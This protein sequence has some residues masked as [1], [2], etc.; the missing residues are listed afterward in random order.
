MSNIILIGVGALGIRLLSRITYKLISRCVN[1]CLNNAQP[2]AK[3]T[4][5]TAYHS[6]ASLSKRSSIPAKTVLHSTTFYHQS[7]FPRNFSSPNYAFVANQLTETYP[8]LLNPTSDG[9]CGIW[10]LLAILKLS[11]QEND[12]TRQNISRII[13]AQCQLL[14][15]DRSFNLPN[16]ANTA[17]SDRNR[18]AQGLLHLETFF[19]NRSPTS[20]SDFKNQLNQDEHLS[21]TTALA[22]RFLSFQLHEASNIS[23]PFINDLIES[24]QNGK[25][26][27]WLNHYTMMS[28]LQL[29][30]I[31]NVPLYAMTIDP[32]GHADKSGNAPHAIW[33]E[34]HLQSHQNS[35]FCIILNNNHYQVLLKHNSDYRQETHEERRSKLTKSFDSMKTTADNKNQALRELYDMYCNS[36]TPLEVKKR[37]AMTVGTHKKNG[38][39]KIASSNDLF[40]L[41][42]VMQ[43][44]VFA[45]LLKNRPQKTDENRRSKL[46]KILENPNATSSEKNESIRKLYEIYFAKNI[47]LEVKRRIAMTIITHPKNQHL[48]ITSARDLFKLGF[49]EQEKIF[50]NLWS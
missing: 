32:K 49:Y 37:I 46:T 45:K 18:I 23:K 31:Q 10:S 43:E 40:N 50:A 44:Q 47:D 34:S 21:E 5:S 20:Y 16:C 11:A 28:T 12:D 26:K 15:E 13:N 14:C 39:F 1:Y 33:E 30:G 36:N 19:N 17:F 6:Q 42:P 35:N 25:P 24:N 27:A 3:R 4:S 22:F 7:T 41:S 29:F 9:N 38:Y 8:F 2:R 48:K